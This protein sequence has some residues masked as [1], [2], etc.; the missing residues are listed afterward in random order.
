MS[1]PTVETVSVKRRIGGC[2]AYRSII[3]YLYRI[4]VNGAGFARAVGIIPIIYHRITD[5]IERR[6]GIYVRGNV[7][8]RGCGSAVPAAG[9][10]TVADD[11]RH[12]RGERV[13]PVGLGGDQVG[14]VR[15]V[16]YPA[17][18]AQGP[19]VLV[20]IAESYGKSLS[21]VLRVNGNVL[22]DVCEHRSAPGSVVTVPGGNGGYVRKSSSRLDLAGGDQRRKIVA[23]ERYRVKPCPARVQDGVRRD[24]SGSKIELVVECIF[25]IPADKSVSFAH[26]RFGFSRPAVF[27]NAL[28]LDLAAAHR[29]ERHGISDRSRLDGFDHDVVRSADALVFQNHA[30]PVR[31]LFRGEIQYSE[32]LSDIRGVN[33]VYFAVRARNGQSY[34][35]DIQFLADKIL[36]FK[37]SGF[38]GNGYGSDFH[39]GRTRDRRR[40]DPQRKQNQ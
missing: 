15:H 34:A 39:R 21:D 27:D 18:F 23:V 35:V 38:F 4:A 2:R 31:R 32:V 24:L 10:A 29:I 7:T 25:G 12:R 5:R 11:L 40:Y 16:F 1:E 37:I 20:A 26:G 28:G 36:G 30:K 6:L 33:V 22:V 8:E 3:S 14:S 13:Y 9:K 17:H 19:A